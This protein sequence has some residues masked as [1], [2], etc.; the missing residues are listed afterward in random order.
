MEFCFLLKWL[1]KRWKSGANKTIL[2]LTP[3]SLNITSSSLPDRIE[4]VEQTVY[5]PLAIVCLRLVEKVQKECDTPV[6][7]ARQGD[8]GGAELARTWF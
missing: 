3:D 2:W 5:G 1:L 7:T 6:W 8:V 4:K